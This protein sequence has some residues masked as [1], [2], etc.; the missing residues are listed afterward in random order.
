MK[1]FFFTLSYLLLHTAV[2]S[3]SKD[4]LDSLLNGLN[5]KNVDTIQLQTN[6]AIGD[7]YMYSNNNKALEYF[8]SAKNIAKKLNRTLDMASNYYS[9]AYCNLMK[10]KYD[11]SLENYFQSVRLY[12]QL[13]DNRRLANAYMSIVSVYSESGNIMKATEYYEKTRLLIES[14]NDTNQLCALFSTKGQIFYKQLMYDSALYYLQK[15]YRLASELK[16]GST[17]VTLLC[18]IGLLYKKMNQPKEALTYCENSLKLLKT[19][20]NVDD[21]YPE[22]YNNIGSIHVVTGNYTEAKKAFDISILY[23]ATS[24]SKALEMEDYLNLSE[25]Y[26]KMNN[27][28]LESAYLKKYYTIKDSVFTHDTRNQ[29]TELEADYQLGKKNIELV[30]KDADIKEQK[31]QR[32]IFIILALATLLLLTALSFFYKRMQ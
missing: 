16:D 5:E 7:Y 19:L 10:G 32:N 12:E 4:V 13:N 9:I 23:A 21:Y 29:M 30:K 6:R 28:K 8:E 1:F 15:Q 31:N 2:L 24:G 20:K 11:I 27:Y 17:E 3:E 14:G 18:N 26:G 25:M 22:V